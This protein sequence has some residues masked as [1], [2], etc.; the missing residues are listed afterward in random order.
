M[1]SGLTLIRTECTLDE[2]LQLAALERHAKSKHILYSSF[3]NLRDIHTT[4]YWGVFSWSI[5]SEKARWLKKK[6]IATCVNLA[7]TIGDV[8]RDYL[9]FYYPQRLRAIRS[10]ARTYE[11]SVSA[12]LF[13]HPSIIRKAIYIDINSAYWTIVQMVGWNVAYLPGK[14]LTPGRAPLDFPLPNSKGA[15]NYLVSIGLRSNVMVWTG[16]RMV[17]RHAYNAHINGSLWLLVQDILHSIAAIAVSLGAIYVH[18]DGC[19]IPSDKADE[20]MEHV[21]SFGLTPRIVAEGTAY[22]CGFGNY[23]IGDKRTKRFEPER[24]QFAFNSV[25]KTQSRWLSNILGEVRKRGTPER[26]FEKSI[27]GHNWLKPNELERK[28]NV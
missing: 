8:V 6:S 11:T 2:Y 1:S 14:W 4:V 23:Q 21:K 18:T 3:P 22:V 20:Y 27:T 13:V 19:I 26:L 5:P 12:P 9:D 17:S 7:S 28:T 15:R 16:Y 10:E 24:A 25:R